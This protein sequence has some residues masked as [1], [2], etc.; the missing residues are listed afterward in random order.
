MP[1]KKLSGPVKAER[2]A[3]VAH[4]ERWSAI[5]FQKAKWCRESG[6]ELAE[7]YTGRGDALQVAAYSI[8]M[9]DHLRPLPTKSAEPPK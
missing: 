7:H 6:D 2:A 8:K 4:L 1:R 5:A 3:I 9:G